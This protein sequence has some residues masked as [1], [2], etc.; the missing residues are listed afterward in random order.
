M[1]APV[2]EVGAGYVAGEAPGGRSAAGRTVSVGVAPGRL[3][4]DV[5]GGATPRVSP[6]DRGVA[7]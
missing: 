2:A 1:T 7:L 3:G 5:L 4:G 6:A